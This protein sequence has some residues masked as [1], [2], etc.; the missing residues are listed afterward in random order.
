MPKTDMNRP[1][2][3]GEM[4][5]FTN[6]LADTFT[7]LLAALAQV[8]ESAALLQALQRTQQL[9][10]TAR[11]QALQEHLLREGLVC[12]QGLAAQRATP[13]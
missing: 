4:L 10:P 12:L 5:E 2:T 11:P 3:T 13:G 8:T 7:V 6:Q 1:I 9:A